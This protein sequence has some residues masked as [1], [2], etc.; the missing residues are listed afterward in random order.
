MRKKPGTPASEAY[1]EALRV[2][3]CQNLR[4]A[5][6]SVTRLFDEHLEPAGL[7]STQFVILAAL[8]AH[9]PSPL[10][11]LSRTLVLERSA[12][13]RSLTPLVRRGLVRLAAPART[14][15][16]RLTA[17]GQRLLAKATPLWQAAQ[18]RFV[19]RLGQGTWAE[20][21]DRLPAAID[22]AAPP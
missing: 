15:T 1:A 2:C 8:G 7:R 13:T 11:Q 22:A 6:R 10:Q 3:A 18:A 17:A 4:S 19:G 9:G 21:L 20:L 5:A 12:L 16:A 14:T